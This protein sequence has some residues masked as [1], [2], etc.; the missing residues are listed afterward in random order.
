M[1]MKAKMKNGLY[2]PDRS[3]VEGSITISTQGSMDKPLLWYKGLVYLVKKSLL[4]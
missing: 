4:N 2:V 1:I 3:V